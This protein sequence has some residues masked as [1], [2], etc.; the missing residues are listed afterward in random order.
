MQTGLNHTRKKNSNCINP[1]DAEAEGKI[2]T[3]DVRGSKVIRLL[4]NKE[5]PHNR[6]KKYRLCGFDI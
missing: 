6:L 2:Y 5:N 3:Q 4:G 1:T